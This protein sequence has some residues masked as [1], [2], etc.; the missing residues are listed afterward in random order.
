MPQDDVR[1]P[2]PDFNRLVMGETGI[3]W[4]NV[5][6]DLCMDSYLLFRTTAEARP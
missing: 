4:N 6:R 3:H 1:L 2:R 5:E